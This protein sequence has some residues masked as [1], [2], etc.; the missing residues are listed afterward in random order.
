MIPPE[1]MQHSIAQQASGVDLAK[2]LEVLASPGKPVSEIPG[3]DNADHVVR[4]VGD[5][6]RLTEVSYKEKIFSYN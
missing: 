2:S 5:V 6:F 3:C 1:I 4:L